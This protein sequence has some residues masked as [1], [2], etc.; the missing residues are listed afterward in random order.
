MVGRFFLTLLKLFL[1]IIVTGMI[2]FQIPEL[3]YDF[4]SKEPVQIN[5]VED[6]SPELF[7]RSTFVSVKG[8]ADFTRAATFAKHGVQ[9]TYFFL[10]GYDTKLV[11]RTAEAVNEDWAEIN[12]HMGR[13]RPYDRMPFSRS[14]RAGFRKLYDIGIDD[15]AM[16][17]ARDDAPKL[18]GWS[19][20][21][22]VLACVLWCVMVYFFFIHSRIGAKRAGASS[23][24][25]H[26]A[27]AHHAEP[28]PTG[29]QPGD[30]SSEADEDSQ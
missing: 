15:D 6:L 5:S 1:L 26:G 14:V 24:S 13:L 29:D 30:N 10:E 19:I 12:F 17:L 28:E 18:S 21:A 2:K 16:F 8:K 7:S 11:V 9:F 3:R 25:G 4:D 23:V 27:P 22:T 20:G